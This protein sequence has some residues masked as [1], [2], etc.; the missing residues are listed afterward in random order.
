MAIDT[1][2]IISAAFETTHELSTISYTVPLGIL[3]FRVPLLARKLEQQSKGVYNKFCSPNKTSAL[4]IFKT[5][6]PY[7]NNV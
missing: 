2:C 7:F 1:V 5:M 3:Y 6:I 4:F